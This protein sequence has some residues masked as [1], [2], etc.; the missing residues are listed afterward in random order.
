MSKAFPQRSPLRYDDLVAEARSRI[1]A[2][3]PAWT[4]HGPAD[5]GVTLIEL[6]SW[7][8]EM[9]DY[10]AGRETEAITRSFLELL[11]GPRTTDTSVELQVALRDTLEQLWTR[12][13]AATAADYE[14]IATEQWPSCPKYAKPLGS[15]ALIHRVRCLPER[16]LDSN[17]K[18][19]PAPG[20]VSLVVLPCEGNNPSKDLLENLWQYLEPRRL[21]TARHHVVGPVYRG[22]RILADVYLHD[23]IVPSTAR[24]TINSA[25]KQFFDPHVGGEDGGGW[26][27]GADVHLSDVY[28]LLDGLDLVDYRQSSTSPMGTKGRTLKGPNNASVGVKIYPTS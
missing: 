6:L 7:I 12:Y 13:R 20:H 17:Q 4:D 27:F 5:V 14:T 22:F 19:T 16:D 26:Q 24:S 10:R 8:V 23:D 28:S 15:K 18:T 21:L 25:L 2:L 11:G 1:P 9:I 3:A